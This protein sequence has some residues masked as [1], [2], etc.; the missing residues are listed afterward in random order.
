MVLDGRGSV[1]SPRKLDGQDGDARA[2]TRALTAADERH[3]T[4]IAAS[5]PPSVG[6]LRNRSRT[7]RMF[8]IWRSIAVAPDRRRMCA[9]LTVFVIPPASQRVANQPPSYWHAD[10]LRRRASDRRAFTQARLDNLHVRDTVGS[11]RS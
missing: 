7:A 2:V 1:L 11:I 3:A 6:V 10:P 8:A 5:A 4:H 9:R